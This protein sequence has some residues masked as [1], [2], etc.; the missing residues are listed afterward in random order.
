MNHR[1]DRFL[2]TLSVERRPWFRTIIERGMAASLPNK[3]SSKCDA[4]YQNV[5]RNGISVAV[6]TSRA[7][8]YE[9]QLQILH[10]RMANYLI[11]NM[12]DPS[13]VWEQGLD[14]EPETE[15]APDD[16]HIL[17]GVAATGQLL[18]YMTLKR[19][20]GFQTTSLSNEQRDDIY[21]EKRFG[22]NVFNSL[23]I[24]PELPLSKVRFGCRFVK[25]HA[26]SVIHPFSIRGPI[27]AAVAGFKSFYHHLSQ[28]VI[29]I[30]GETEEQSVKRNFNYFHIPSVLVYA[31]SNGIDTGLMAKFYERT[32][33][34][35]AFL[36]TDLHIS[37]P[38]FA[39]VEKVLEVPG[40]DGIGALINLGRSAREQ[41]SSLL[42]SQVKV[43]STSHN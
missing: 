8:S 21:L 13:H 28:E 10:Y 14:H 18:C 20:E 7:F 32:S 40:S 25:N 39:E 42:N 3:F 23:C 31:R 5:D 6:L 4:L 1:L 34:P 11:S 17:S 24:L 38:R 41:R 27:E 29:A 12:F 9:E 35:F 22:R 26:Y 19:V 37:L 33:Y 2:E 15:L 16:I 43:S 30:I 36:T